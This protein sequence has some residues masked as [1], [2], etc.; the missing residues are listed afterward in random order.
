[1]GWGEGGRSCRSS[2]SRSSGWAGGF[3]GGAVFSVTWGAG[4]GRASVCRGGFFAP[5]SAGGAA[6]SVSRRAS[7]STASISRCSRPAPYSARISSR[8]KSS[9]NAGTSVPPVTPLSN[10]LSSLEAML[11]L[12]SPL[13][14]RPFRPSAGAP[15]HTA[16]SPRRRRH[17]GNSASPAWEYSPKSRSSR[18]PDGSCRPPRC[19]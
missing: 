2:S 4:R 15:P 14:P 17:S 9:S 6:G 7:C 13:C 19:R 16:G 5:P 3:W 11:P 12:S 18:R 1:M 8:E 10:S